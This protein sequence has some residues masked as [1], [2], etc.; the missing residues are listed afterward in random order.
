MEIWLLLLVALAAGAGGPGGIG[1][2]LAAQAAQL[3]SQS[4][5]K[6]EEELKAARYEANRWRTQ[7]ETDAWRARWLKLA[8]IGGIEAERDDLRSQLMVANAAVAPGYARN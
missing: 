1:W 7:A 4:F 6:T 2:S 8:R 3:Q 5:G